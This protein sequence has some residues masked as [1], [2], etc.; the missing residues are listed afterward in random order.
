[1]VGGLDDVEV[2]FDDEHRV[3]GIDQALQHDEQLPHILEVQARRRLVE[4]VERLSR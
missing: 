2:V 3:A 1:M 4:D